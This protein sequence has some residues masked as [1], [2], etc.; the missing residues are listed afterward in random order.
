MKGCSGT[1]SPFFTYS[2][3]PSSM[4]PLQLLRLATS[5]RTS[6]I[7]STNPTAYSRL[8]PAVRVRASQW[9]GRALLSSSQ[10]R[11]S[12]TEGKER[13]KGVLACLMSDFPR[14]LGLRTD[15]VHVHALPQL[16]GFPLIV[17]LGKTTT[18]AHDAPIVST[19]YVC[20]E[21][22]APPGELSPV[23]MGFYWEI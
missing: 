5:A 14:A 13:K 9:H 4:I 17:S 21:T 12:Q 10:R 18:I 2:G 16:P 20:M 7:H 15:V 19:Q 11:L 3:T 1:R 22:S 8:A 23:Q 6:I